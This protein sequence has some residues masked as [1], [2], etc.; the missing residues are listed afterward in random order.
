MKLNLKSWKKEKKEKNMLDKLKKIIE[1]KSQILEGIKNTVFKKEHVEIVAQ[2]RM[3]ICKTNVCGYYDP[4]GKSKA[5]VIPGQPSCGA[6]G[7]SLELK[8]RCMSCKCGLETL[9]KIPLWV[10]IT[11]EDD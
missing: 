8:T 10:Q 7:C 2:A 6:C 11:E 3:D 4:E 9:N 1:N 5:A